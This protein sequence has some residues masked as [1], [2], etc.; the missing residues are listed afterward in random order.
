MILRKFAFRR[1]PAPVRRA[2]QRW[3][4]AFGNFYAAPPE[5]LWRKMPRSRASTGD[6][7]HE[8]NVAQTNSRHA[9]A[10]QFLGRGRCAPP[11]ECVPRTCRLPRWRPRKLLTYVSRPVRAHFLIPDR[12]LSGDRRNERRP[13][14]FWAEPRIICQISGIFSRLSDVTRGVN[15]AQKRNQ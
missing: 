11:Q 3:Q 14:P 1:G 7:I 10:R 12:P 2:P 13:F 15:G 8:G 5:H 6:H 4:N 9:V